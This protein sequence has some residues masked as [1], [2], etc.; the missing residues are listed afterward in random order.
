[1]ACS[2]PNA[3]W[4]Q[5]EGWM[6]RRY[7]PII[8]VAALNPDDVIMQKCWATVNPVI[9]RATEA[10][11]RADEQPRAS[12]NTTAHFFRMQFVKEQQTFTLQRES[13]DCKDS[14]I[15]H[16]QRHCN[17]HSSFNRNY[18][19]LLRVEAD[20]NKIRATWELHQIFPLVGQS[21]HFFVQ[22]AYC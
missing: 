9:L 19:F 4:K 8:T 10:N 18:Y 13:G 7:Y 16:S 12:H 2:V 21:L 22:F 3:R 20:A 15:S 11:K 5:S 1:V 17:L 6:E 14:S